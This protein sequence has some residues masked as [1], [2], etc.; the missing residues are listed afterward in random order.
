MT[1]DNDAAPMDPPID[2]GSDEALSAYLAGEL[3]EQGDTAFAA[4]L[5]AEPMLAA[6]LDALAGALMSLADI[7]L[8]EGFD[9]RLGERLAAEAAAGDLAARRRRTAQR[10]GGIATAAAAVAVL[11]IAGGRILTPA[12]DD[13]AREVA[14]KDGAE[15]LSM[16]A[17]VAAGSAQDLSTTSGAERSMM[18]PADPD[19]SG[20]VDEFAAAPEGGGEA[21]GTTGPSRD[22]SSSDGGGSGA[23]SPSMAA[24]PAEERQADSASGPVIADEQAAFT[25]DDE[26]R[27]YY[28]G[29]PEA[30]RL[31]GMA[32]DEAA[33][34]AAR[35][36]EQVRAAGPFTSGVR[37]DA[38]LDEVLQMNQGPRIVAR[39]EWIQW[40]DGGSL[41][42]VLA[43][44]GPESTAIDAFELW[45]VQP[46]GCGLRR[47]LSWR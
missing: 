33:E 14:L 23:D 4:R 11:A 29:R 22:G 15:S 8:P 35:H 34:T 24:A 13:S 5:A 32:R 3:D 28:Q 9:E 42:Y 46:D 43:V 27:A 21:A 25:T 44:A 31:R 16:E 20:G 41:A 38:C 47:H 18:A 30:E 6:Q 26:L 17:G 45:V 7:D 12:G 40:Q 10:W 37:P 1:Q 19:G 36:A 39:A 2:P